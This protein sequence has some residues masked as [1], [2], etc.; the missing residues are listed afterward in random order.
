MRYS[1][2]DD[3]LERMRSRRTRQ[4]RRK[5]ED[6]DD[7]YYLDQDYEDDWAEDGLEDVY[8]EDRP[9]RR[10]ARS[11]GTRKTASASGS[12][13]SQRPQ[14]H[15][16]TASRSAS[17]SSR[18]ASASG[19]PNRTQA[20][21]GRS[22]SQA[23]YARNAHRKKSRGRLIRN[24]L[25]ALIA[26][27]VVYLGW[28]FLHRQTGTW[29]IAIFGVDSRDSS[30]DE[31]TH[32]DVQMICTMDRETGEIKLVSVYRDTYMK[33]S[34]DGKYHKIN[35]AYFDGGHEQAVQA[36]EENLDLSVD[37][38]ATFNWKAVAE[39]IN[40]L[41]GIDLEIT[42]AEFKY[43]NAFITE[44]VE[45]TGIGSV[46]LEHAGANHLDGV[47]AVAY[48]RL[49]LMDTDFQRTERQR[50]VIS[51]ALEKAKAA[52]VGTLTTLVMTV[53]P[54]LSTDIGVDDLLPMAKDAGKYY[55]GETA[56]FPFSRQSEKIGRMDCVVPT[57]LASNVQ[58]L[59]V[60][61]Y[62]D[63]NY[64][65]PSSV[66]KISDQISQDSGL[67][68]E[69]EPA[70]SGNSGSGSGQGQSS[71]TQA[72]AAEATVPE[73]TT[74]A[75]T[76][77]EETTEEVIIEELETTASQDEEE[78]TEEI[79]PGV[80]RPSRETQADRETEEDEPDSQGPGVTETSRPQT[81]APSSEEQAPSSQTQGP[82]SSGPGAAPG[83]D[84]QAE[85]AEQAQGPGAAG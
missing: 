69:G 26:I 68:E 50:K 41:G 60:F 62:G 4:V 72:P 35:Q 49:R 36:L 80:T 71:A 18:T 66:Q 5:Q 55:I 77:A 16:Q 32:A 84:S 37:N 67:Y 27:V 38:Y 52:D 43:I 58:Q 15:T 25:L 10:P 61:L 9:N 23:H 47:Q 17:G 79:G 24:I 53:L 75:E 57:T 29:T 13:R 11:S 83:A 2:E 21:H 19:R 45:S 22:D 74:E 70:P 59:H 33:V 1:N 40:I 20:G 44:T 28:S 34:S 14:R 39:G 76:S 48:S 12:S 64:R 73:E 6:Y 81:S 51:L 65:V 54:Q 42:D 82:G 56:G 78:E 31:G 7:D 46:H 3:E 85:E 30:V 8:I 63:E